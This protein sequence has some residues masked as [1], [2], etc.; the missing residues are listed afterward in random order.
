MGQHATAAADK[1]TA[2]AL[3]QAIESLEADQPRVADRS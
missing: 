2:E 3:G 1:K